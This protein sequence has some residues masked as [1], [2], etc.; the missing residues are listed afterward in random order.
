MPPTS[1]RRSSAGSASLLSAIGLLGLGI[2]LGWLI[3]E[4]FNADDPWQPSAMPTSAIALEYMTPTPVLE[5]AV[6]A[7]DAAALADDAAALADDAAALADDAAA[8]ATPIEVA[9]VIEPTA[10]DTEEPYATGTPPPEAAIPVLPVIDAGM[11]ERLRAIHQVG[12]AYGKQPNVFMK[13][14]DSITVAGQFLTDFG[15]GLENLGEHGDLAPVVEYFRAAPV[16][17][18]ESYARCGAANS[19][20]RKS[21][22]STV[23]WSAVQVLVPFERAEARATREAEATLV[24]SAAVSG[25]VA[26]DALAAGAVVTGTIPNG[27]GAAEAPATI[28]ETP[29]PR[30][31]P[32][33][34][35]LPPDDTPLRCEMKLTQASIALIMFGTNDLQARIPP[36][37]YKA[38]LAEIAAQ[39]EAAG[40]I[41]VLS[42]IPPRTDYNSANARVSSYN[43]AVAELAQERRIPLLN[44]WAA[45]NGPDMVYQGMAGDGIHPEAFAYGSSLTPRGLQFGQNQRNLTALQILDKLKRIVIEDGA[46]E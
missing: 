34:E 20:T 13:V 45:L 22:A 32:P 2:G 30:F 41:P 36:A 29:K 39:L 18:G 33:P 9:L 12:L 44:Y 1:R 35:C 6:A 40:V 10:T 8:L 37:Q 43:M 3:P 24:A 15:C 21:I 25:T 38:T 42:T 19:F 23:G 7:D 16:P 4:I 11:K 28:T 5:A 31:V 14:G 27:T 26:T 46:P 17:I